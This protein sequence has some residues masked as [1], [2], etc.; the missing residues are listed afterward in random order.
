MYVV[1]TLIGAF[2]SPVWGVVLT[3][4]DV[5]E[6]QVLNMVHTLID[7]LK[8]PVWNVVL[9]E[10]CVSQHEDLVGCDTHG[11]SL[12]LSDDHH[13]CAFLGKS[14]YFT[15]LCCSFTTPIF[16]FFTTLRF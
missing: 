4:I 10:H 2:E 6:S 13:H 9:C 3:L 15:F 8:G 5:L 7:V 11:R 1:L 16:I 14:F 12:Q